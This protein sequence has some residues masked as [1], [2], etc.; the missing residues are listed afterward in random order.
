MTPAEYRDDCQ[1][2]QLPFGTKPARRVCGVK[3]GDTVK[4]YQKPITRLDYEGEARIVRV[5][6][7]KPV[8][9]FDGVRYFSCVVNFPEDGP[10]TCVARL[11]GEK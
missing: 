11:V 9:V 3:V 2:K 4:V 6:S 5:L 1:Q 8:D 10:D 7:K